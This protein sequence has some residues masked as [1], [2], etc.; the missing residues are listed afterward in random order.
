[1]LAEGVGG[2]QDRVHLGLG[3]GAALVVADFQ[4]CR[5]QGCD[6]LWWR[7]QVELA[8][9]PRGNAWVNCRP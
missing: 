8:V 2:P 4:S 3:G 5:T 6:G 1:M 9:V 7:R